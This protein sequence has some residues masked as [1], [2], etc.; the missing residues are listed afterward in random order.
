MQNSG[1]VLEKS[2]RVTCYDV[3]HSSEV[4]TTASFLMRTYIINGNDGCY[5]LAFIRHPAVYCAI[6]GVCAN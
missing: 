2:C 4:F 1:V 5:K 3:I 6:D